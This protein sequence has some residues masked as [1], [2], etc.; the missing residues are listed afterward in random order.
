MIKK[1]TKLFLGH[2]Q[3]EYIDQM[4]HHAAIFMS[5]SAPSSLFGF[6]L[7]TMK[8]VFPFV[9]SIFFFFYSA[10]KVEYS[11]NGP[12]DVAFLMD[13]SASMLEAY[14]FQSQIVAKIASRYRLSSD[15]T[16]ASLIIYSRNAQ[17]EL[18]LKDG[19]SQEVLQQKLSS[20][21]FL[22]LD[23]RLDR[24]LYIA[25]LALF[26]KKYGARQGV[27]KILYVFTDGQQSTLDG[28]A[29][30]EQAQKLR[31]LGVQIV[32]LGVGGAVDRNELEKLGNVND[33]VYY[34]NSFYDL[35]TDDAMIEGMV[36]RTF[37]NIRKLCK[38]FINSL[39]SNLKK[40]KYFSL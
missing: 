28:S 20:L 38:Y 5:I 22:G 35:L 6:L 19:I 36:N 3:I 2:R 16:R 18:L 13:S 29:L 30:F 7:K 32:V 17:I 14:S 15:R 10:G 39:F 4:F 40:K 25:Q 34:P 27:P 31:Q 8:T 23:T 1:V 9:L 24:G 33:K 11:A 26:A 12:I 21:P 37:N